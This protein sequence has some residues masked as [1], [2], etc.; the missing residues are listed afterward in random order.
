MSY[1]KIFFLSFLM[2]VIT[3]GFLFDL[4]VKDKKIISYKE[5]SKYFCIEHNDRE[6]F[7]WN[8]KLSMY[9]DFLSK[10]PDDKNFKFKRDVAKKMVFEYGKKVEDPKE[11]EDY[12]NFDW[13]HSYVETHQ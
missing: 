1:I 3:Y 6:F 11:C 5:M 13:Y 10:Y 9:N 12:D 2:I 8:D 7:R 4:H